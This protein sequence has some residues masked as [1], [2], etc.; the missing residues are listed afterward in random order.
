MTV[1]LKGSFLDVIGQ[2]TYFGILSSGARWNVDKTLLKLV[3]ALFIAM[4]I[5]SKAVFKIFF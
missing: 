4:V 1:G 5:G 3:V 2:K